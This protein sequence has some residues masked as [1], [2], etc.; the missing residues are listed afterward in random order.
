MSRMRFAVGAVGAAVL[1][2]PAAAAEQYHVRPYVNFGVGETIDGLNLNDLTESSQGFSDAFRTARAA[3]DISTGEH[4]AYASIIGGNNTVIQAMTEFGETLVVRGAAGTDFTLDFAFEGTIV[5]D[6]KSIP[7][8]G[9]YQIFA[10]VDMAV[11][12]PGVAAW[13]TWWDLANSTDQ[14]LFY[15]NFSLGFVNPSEDIDEIVDEVF[16]FTMPLTTNHE[17]FHVFTRIQIFSAVNTPQTVILDFENTGAFGFVADP[18]AEVQSASGVL[19][20][21]TPIEDPCPADRDGDGAAT[22][23]DLL[24]YLG[25]FRAGDADM[26]GD[27]ETTVTDLLA[28]LG[29]FRQGC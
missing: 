3:V 1:A 6:A 7:E 15:D 12:R 16:S 4:R 28:F 21:T 2:V 11:F 22:V 17:R 23:Q 10:I 18:V 5:A 20:G 13:N 19:P 26:D 14:E 29:A 9:T 8:G 25:S 27:G 24:A